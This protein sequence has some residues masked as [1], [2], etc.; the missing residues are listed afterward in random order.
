VNRRLT[1]VLFAALLASCASRPTVRA[2]FDPAA[3]FASYRTYTWQAKPIAGSPLM[4]QRIVDGIDAKLQAKGWKLAPDGDIRLAANVTAQRQEYTTYYGGMGYGWGWDPMG[5][6]MSSTAVHTYEVGTLVVD[7]FDP[8]T[9][10]V[11]WHGTA[12]GV[13]PDDPDKRMALLQAAL[14]K[15]FAEF[16]PGSSPAK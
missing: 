10:R 11:V 8:T 4:A 1:L 15:M 6:G 3:K 16:P 13:L 14:D 7:M 2:D 9:K 5:P 12:D